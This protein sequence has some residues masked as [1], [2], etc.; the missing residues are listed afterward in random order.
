MALLGPLAFLLH[1][2]PHMHASSAPGPS[3][4]ACVRPACVL[5]LAQGL[6]A[7]PLVG[8]YMGG[9]SMVRAIEQSRAKEQTA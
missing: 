7:V 5:L 8:L 1:T 2:H 4:P 3:S 9:A 6:L